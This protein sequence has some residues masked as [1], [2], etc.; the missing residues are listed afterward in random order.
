[1]PEGSLAEERRLVAAAKKMALFAAGVATQKYMQ[2]I[3]NEQ[4]IMG[5]IAN[6]TYR[7]VCHGIGSAA[8]TEIRGAQR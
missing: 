8:R 4:E 2:A 7:N 6:M 5:A 1:M 3:Q